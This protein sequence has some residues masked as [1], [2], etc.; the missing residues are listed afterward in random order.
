MKFDFEY[1]TTVYHDLDNLMS[2]EISCSYHVDE[3]RVSFRI[4]AK[5][6]E[7]SD[8]NSSALYSLPLKSLEK[9]VRSISVLYD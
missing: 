6:D 3:P 8:Y 2:M 5:P 4:L 1:K 9:L 7:D